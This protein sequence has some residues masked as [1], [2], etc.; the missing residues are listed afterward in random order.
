VSHSLAA[1]IIAVISPP[2]REKSLIRRSDVGSRLVLRIQL[3]R[4]RADAT[5]RGAFRKCAAHRHDGLFLD[6][7][8]RK[9]HALEPAKFLE[10]F[11]S[12]HVHAP[13]QLEAK[14]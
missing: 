8:R 4:R 9:P 6:P 7:K 12:G 2:V 1:Q 3:L 11:R 5:A 14:V 10:L 13:S